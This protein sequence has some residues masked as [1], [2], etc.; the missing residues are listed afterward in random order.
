MYK[1]SEP[2]GC[3]ITKEN[4]RNYRGHQTSYKTIINFKSQFS[5]KVYNTQEKIRCRR[6]LNITY[7]PKDQPTTTRKALKLAHPSRQH[8]VTESPLSST[9]H[10]GN[11]L[12]H[13][14]NL[15]STPPAQQI[16]S[17]HAHESCFSQGL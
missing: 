1:L 7:H 17:L 2:E 4:Y 8:E 9:S 13:Q 16:G 14:Q 10:R 12:Y 5:N 11:D 3:Y 15:G 6:L